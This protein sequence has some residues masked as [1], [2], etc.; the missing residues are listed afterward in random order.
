MVTKKQIKLIKSLAFKKNRIKHLLFI[1]EGHKIVAELLDSNYEI[2]SLFAT[3]DWISNNSVNNV[4]Q[5]TNSDLSRISNQKSPNEV[6]ALV[7]IKK[8]QI[9]HLD[10]ITLVL[11]NINDPGNLGTIVRACDW[12]GVKQIICS[13]DTVDIYNPKVVQSAM[14][15]LLRINVSYT[16]LSDYLRNVSKPIYGAYMHGDNILDMEFPKD[17]CLIMGNEAHGISTEISQ[18][19]DYQSS[20]RNIGN[21]AESL[22]VAMATSIFLYEISN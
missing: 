19:I 18:Y 5:V 12:F 13:R 3:I 17:L 22:N 11:D 16:D 9:L 8:N 6:L 1:V 4:I 20:I 21:S 10:G 15:S 7:K 2:V 14:G